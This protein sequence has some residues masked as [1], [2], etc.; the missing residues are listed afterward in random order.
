M[1]VLPGLSEAIPHIN[2]KG[3]LPL[4]LLPLMWTRGLSE[5]MLTTTFPTNAGITAA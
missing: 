4:R 2:I 1:D 3:G 5:R